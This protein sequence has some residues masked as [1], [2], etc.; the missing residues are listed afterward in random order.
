MRWV[1]VTADLP[2][3]SSGALAYGHSEAVDASTGQK[4]LWVSVVEKAFA[5]FS[6]T[7]AYIEN[8][9]LKN[10]PAYAEALSSESVDDSG[11]EAIWGGARSS[12]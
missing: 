11:Y 8:Y 2:T 1:T 10:D 9:L 3:T 7:E 5:A 4:E 6:A 12:P